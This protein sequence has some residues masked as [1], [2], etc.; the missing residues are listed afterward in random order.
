M[1]KL[2]YNPSLYYKT[3]ICDFDD[4]LSNT[5]T[6]DWKNSKPNINV[7]NKINELYGLG[8]QIIIL[9]ARGQISCNGDCNMA[10][11]KYRK[12]IEYWL[13]ANNVKYSK[14][15]FNKYLGLNYVDDKNLHIEEFQ[16]LFVSEL[17][18]GLSGSEIYVV[19][20]RVYKTNKNILNEILW[21]KSVENTLNIPKIFTFVG[22]TLCMEFLKQNNDFNLL[23]IIDSINKIK[24]IENKNNCDFITYIDRISEHCKLSNDFFEILPEMEIFI[25]EYNCFK[26][27]SHGDLTLENMFFIDGKLYLIDP[28]YDNNFYSSYLLDVSK[29]MFSLRK[30][31]L[32]LEY[33][34]LLNYFSNVNDINLIRLLELLEITQ[35]IR[36]VKY[37]KIDEEKQMLKQLIKNTLNDYFRKYK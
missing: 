15:S 28:I 11:K 3:I 24:V 21:Y 23:T 9:T 5:I 35:M 14:L 8:W 17:K 18:L 4:T 27:F 16:D 12:D 32:L 10:D 29:L 30:N 25:N 22:N 34:E 37:I 26:S 1:N 19:D 2:D 33:N 13:K 31:N 36:V 6:K 20:D 7:I